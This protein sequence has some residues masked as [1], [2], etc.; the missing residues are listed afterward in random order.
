MLFCSKTNP[1]F[2]VTFVVFC[3]CLENF[4]VRQKVVISFDVRSRN[5]T[6][7]LF[8]AYGKGDYLTITIESDGSVKAEC[9]NGGGKW[10]VEVIPESSICNGEFHS[11]LL[12]K[13][14]KTL[15]LSLNGK[16][17]ESTSL[18]SSSSADTNSPAYFGGLP[19][20]KLNISYHSTC[21]CM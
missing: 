9:N 20:K 15:K 14:Q 16:M 12:E 3:I 7:T 8:H 11:I 2:L 13:N 1:D 4:N 19:G 5:K 18:K 10:A 21:E 6:G 17:K